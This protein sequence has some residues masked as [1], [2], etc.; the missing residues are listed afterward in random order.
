MNNIE[1]IRTLTELD[2]HTVLETVPMRI[3]EYKAVCHEKTAA[4]VSILEKLSLLFSEQ[5]DQKGSQVASTKHPIHIRLSADYLL[6]LG[7]TISDWISLKWAFESA[8]HGEQLA[9][10][11]FIDGNLERLVVTSEEFVEAFAGYLILQTNGQFEPYIDEFNDNQV[12]DWRLVRVTQYSQ[13]LSEVNWQDVTA[14]FIN[15]TL[16][17][18]NQ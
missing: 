1:K 10:A 14:Q 16:P 13:Q 2:T 6:N 18:M 9:V 12:Y 17:V 11:F 4:S 8:W 7:I 3:D 5:L 15:S